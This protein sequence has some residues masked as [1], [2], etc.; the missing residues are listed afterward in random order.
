MM[1]AVA[2]SLLLQ[3]TAFAKDYVLFTKGTE[4]ESYNQIVTKLAAGDTIQFSDGNRFQVEKVLSVGANAI[5][6]VGNNVV[7]RLPGNFSIGGQNG[8]SIDR[9]KVGHELLVKNG[10]PVVEISTKFYLK[11]EYIAIKKIP[12]VF[13]LEAF[14]KTFPSLPKAKQE[15]AL[16]KL[17]DWFA[18]AAG[19]EEI[20]DFHRGQL[21]FTGTEWVLFDWDD[22]HKIS[23]RKA[24]TLTNHPLWNRLKFLHPENTVAFETIQ[25]R[26]EKRYPIGNYLIRKPM[27]CLMNFFGM[28]ARW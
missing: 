6:D 7:L 25:T 11:G 3:N 19:M 5:V 8:L 18:Q 26:I 1:L 16:S 21:G 12:I 9:F 22:L 13:T 17:S 24:T 23:K 27:A 20:A 15:M 10:V 2:A 14:L 4:H 28:T